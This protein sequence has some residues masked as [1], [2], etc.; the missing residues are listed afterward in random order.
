MV[1]EQEVL[2]A[3]SKVTDPELHRDVVSLGMIKDMKVQGN[4]TVDFTLEL[5]TP[6]CPLSEEIKDNVR[7]AAES[8]K[9]VNS[10]SMKVTARVQPGKF[11]TSDDL[12]PGVKNVIAVASGKGGVGKTT[13]AVNMAVALAMAGAKVGILDADIYGPTVPL[14]LHV[15]ER[16]ALE[17]NKIRPP[18]ALG[19]K[20]I[21]LGFFYND[22]TPLIWRGPMVAAA[23][24][25]FLTDVDWG[26]LDYLVVDLPP[27]TGD[28]SLTLAQTIPLSGVVIVTTPQ[29][30][31]LSV[32]TKALAMF[33]KLNVPIIGIIENMSGFVCPH[34]GK[35]TE[36]F[37][38]GGA[39]KASE[40]FREN[41]IGE[42][43]LDVDIRV[44]SDMGTPVVV[45]YP[46]SPSAKA[47]NH[48]AR[49]AAGKVSVLT[50]PKAPS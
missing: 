31:A 2:A 21:S 15:E 37:G 3:L 36:V 49:V 14:M 45:A 46:N 7:R 38:R 12:L 43:P 39:R 48:L 26:E 33:K 8:V 27:G 6:A 34:C 25:Q 5:T 9:G 29:D 23:V 13:V 41:Y 47:F 42:I 20:V 4:G 22:S 24:K 50:H 19:V 18:I 30:A 35:M 40:A 28:A 17:G 16:P 44:R 10:V 1:T 11:A 32:A